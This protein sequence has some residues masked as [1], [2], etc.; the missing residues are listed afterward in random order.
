LRWDDGALGAG[1]LVSGAATA[2]APQKGPIVSFLPAGGGQVPKSI[3][4]E[5]HSPTVSKLILLIL[6]E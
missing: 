1:A 5:Y 3:N 4:G 6:L 2:L